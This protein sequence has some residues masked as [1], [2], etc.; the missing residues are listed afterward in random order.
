MTEDCPTCERSLR[1]S[2]DACPVC[3]S[4][5]TREHVESSEGLA[6][7]LVVPWCE[8]CGHAWFRRVAG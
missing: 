5:D 6:D 8:D 7:G 2:P 3:D 1:D 4:A